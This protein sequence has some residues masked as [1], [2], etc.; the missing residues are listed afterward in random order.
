MLISYL[1]CRLLCGHT[2]GV[3]ASQVFISQSSYGI[4]GSHGTDKSILVIPQR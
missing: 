2:G 3:S 4:V 1:I